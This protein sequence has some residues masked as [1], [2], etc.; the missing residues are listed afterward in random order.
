MA[1]RCATWRWSGGYFPSVCGWSIKHM[2]ASEVA[3]RSARPGVRGPPALKGAPGAHVYL[4]PGRLFTPH[5]RHVIAAGVLLAIV[6]CTLQAAVELRTRTQKVTFVLTNIIVPVGMWFYWFRVR[7]ATLVAN[8]LRRF[9]LPIFILA[10]GLVGWA[11]VIPFRFF[12]PDWGGW[13]G[14]ACVAVFAFMLL[15]RLQRGMANY[16][17]VRLANQGG[18][19]PNPQESRS[20]PTPDP[21]PSSPTAPA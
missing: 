19:V 21:P 11:A 8:Q 20:P 4:G 13:L 9:S 7:L 14:W 3:W 12:M 6:V 17:S 5:R 2:D 18:I 1:K 16:L 15:N 10:C